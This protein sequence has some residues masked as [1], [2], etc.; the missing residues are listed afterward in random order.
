MRG[1]RLSD[2][3]VKEIYLKCDE[4]WTKAQIAKYLY[5]SRKA[6]QGAIQRGKEGLFI[7]GKKSL[8]RRKITTKATDRA[9]INA[10]KRN[11][12]ACFKEFGKQCFD[13][14]NTT[15]FKSM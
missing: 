15:L 7:Q 4:G 14:Y 9:I 8:G 13:W 3:L 5:V 6:V 2:E 1:K 10:V 12:F 11:R